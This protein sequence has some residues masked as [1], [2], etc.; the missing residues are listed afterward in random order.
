MTSHIE[1]PPL[2]DKLTLTVPE[3]GA[4]SGH[5]REGGEGRRAQR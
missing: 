5:T 1:E 4:L 3:A 2:R